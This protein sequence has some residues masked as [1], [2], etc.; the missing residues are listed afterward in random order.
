MDAIKIQKFTNLDRKAIN[1][2]TEELQNFLIKIDPLKRLKIVK[3]FGEK[4]SDFM[5]KKI[6][7]KDGAIFVAKADKKTV[8]FIAGIIE[9]QREEDHLGLVES[10]GGRVI[11]LI[12]NEKYRGQNIGKILMLAM[13]N[14]FKTKNCDIIRVEVFV[15]NTNAIKFYKKIKYKPRLIDMIKTIK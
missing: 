11:E 13:E 10:K 2:L 4:Y 3:D 1:L 7:E 5:F 15:P 14:F 6:L 9:E 8:G 12:I